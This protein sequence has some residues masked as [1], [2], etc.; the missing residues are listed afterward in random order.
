MTKEELELLKEKIIDVCVDAGHEGYEGVN[1]C[2]CLYE[3]D[4]RFNNTPYANVDCSID[5]S[6]YVEDDFHCGYMNGT[7]AFVVTNVC[8]SLKV[9]AFDKDG[10]PV[11]ID[12]Y[13]L[14]EAI[15]G[16]LY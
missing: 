16:C 7:G 14:E 8:V 11:D 2:I 4:D 6:G 12:E 5:I 9:E 13:E 15:K 10:T 3:D 1:N